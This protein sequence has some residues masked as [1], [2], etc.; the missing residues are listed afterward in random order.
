VAKEAAAQ[1]SV[2][3]K[4]LEERSSLETDEKETLLTND[5]RKLQM[6]LKR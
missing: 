2:L 5:K 3:L 1:A 6:E 4:E